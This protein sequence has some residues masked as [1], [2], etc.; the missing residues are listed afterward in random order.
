MFQI[1]DHK[2]QI[3]FLLNY[4]FHH[5]R[6]HLL[7]TQIIPLNT[8]RTFGNLI[9]INQQKIITDQRNVANELRLPI[10]CGRDHKRQRQR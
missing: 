5:L 9:C 6:L 10:R 2:S 3:Y 7:I 4:A 8:C 1:A